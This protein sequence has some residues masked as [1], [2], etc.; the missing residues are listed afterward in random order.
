M[1]VFGIVLIVLNLLAGAGFIYLATQD[2]KGR[3]TITAA[4]LRHI[5]LLQGLPLTPP[6]GTTDDF[7]PEDQTPFVVEMAG[8]DTTKTVSKKLLES[9]FQTNAPAAPAIA[10]KVALAPGGPVV[11]NQVAEVKRV[12]GIINAELAKDA[13][14][15]DKLALLTNWLLH[16][17]ETSDLRRQYLALTSLNDDKGQPKTA[18]KLAEDVKTLSAM[19]DARF[20]AVI[21]PPQSMAS[22]IDAGDRNSPE[23]AERKGKI[24]ALPDDQKLAESAKWRGGP[25]KD[26]SER[27]A[28]LAHL[29]VHL[30]KDAAW[31]KRVMV[32]VGMR[33]YVQAITAQTQRFLDMILAAERSIP[34]DQA[35][36]ARHEMML[37]E[38]ATQ[39]AQRAKDVSD[40]RAAL[41]E[42]KTQQDDAVSRRQTQLDDLV[43]QL[44]KVKSEV[45]ELLVRQT[46]IEKQ[47]F[48]LQREVSLTLEEVYRLEAL[49]ARV[50][51][52]RYGLPPEKP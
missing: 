50:E 4:G 8:G 29:L 26:E 30:D 12:Q 32:I 45:D 17:A 47:L 19:L 18:E 22:P 52:E 36:F 23:Y 14:A 25:A 9:Y 48:E 34:D 38:R 11:T 24:D 44:N 46:G 16:Q 43:K 40:V 35:V 27:R 10:G 3:Q 21:D 15:A 1:R 51:R 39:F 41:T 20:K 5:L 2:W 6:P 31:Q 13:P 42:Q 33:R 7:D 28:R 37:R 49:L